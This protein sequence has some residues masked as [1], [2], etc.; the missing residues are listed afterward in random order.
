[1]N[2][3][4]ETDG[5]EEAEIRCSRGIGLDQFVYLCCV[6]ESRVWLTACSRWTPEAGSEA[7][8]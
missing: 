2:L 6:V 4:L 1:M 7:L 5:L 3:Y 8:A